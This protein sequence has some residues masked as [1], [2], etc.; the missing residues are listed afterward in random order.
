MRY[1]IPNVLDSFL[2]SINEKKICKW[3]DDNIIS[4]PFLV[5]KKKQK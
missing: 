5:V 2:V 4:S 3:L 1:V